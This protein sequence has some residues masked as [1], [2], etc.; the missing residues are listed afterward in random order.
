[1]A[2]QGGEI[3]RV[4]L[5]RVG[6]DHL[7]FFMTLELLQQG[8]D[9]GPCLLPF[10]VC[11]QR[12]LVEFNRPLRIPCGAEHLGL[13]KVGAERSRINIQNLIVDG[14]G[15]VEVAL[16][17]KDLGLDQHHIHVLRVIS[18]NVV[19]GFEGFIVSLAA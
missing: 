13:A 19:Q 18:E 7:R 10:H 2:L 3:I 15:L 4:E 5:Q 6:I 14:G 16:L 1:M 8:A 11:P 12:L 9:L 17:H